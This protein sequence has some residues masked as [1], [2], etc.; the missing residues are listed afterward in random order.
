MREGRF[1]GGEP[2]GRRVG[3]APR[4]GPPVTSASRPFS[5]SVIHFRNASTGRVVVMHA[6][7]II[8]GLAAHALDDAGHP[9]TTRLLDATALT[10]K[11]A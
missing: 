7:R 8:E 10:A 2:T 6:G 5:R 1:G 9:E 11:W 4:C 3:R